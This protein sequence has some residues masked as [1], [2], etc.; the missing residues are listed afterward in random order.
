MPEASTRPNKSRPKR[1]PES[2]SGRE[3]SQILSY[4]GRGA[5]ADRSVGVNLWTGGQVTSQALVRYRSNDYSVPIRFGHQEV[6]IR[7]YVNEVMIGCRGRSLPAM[8]SYEREDMIFDPVHYLSL[9]EQKL[10]ALDQAAPL[11]GRE[12][13]EAFATL[14]RLIEARMNKHGRREYVQVLRL[15]ESFEL[16]NLHGA[17]KHAFC[18]TISRAGKQP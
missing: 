11:Q 6:W 9:I 1:Q 8:R 2:S 15:L 14:R 12:P 7:G 13:P 4:A 5:I 3:P 18:S 16:A 10:G 17:G